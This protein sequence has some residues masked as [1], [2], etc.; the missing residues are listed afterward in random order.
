M[1]RYLH[2]LR[3][4][5]VE[6]TGVKNVDPTSSLFISEFS[7]WIEKR[8]R[9]GS[10]YLELL[11]H[12]RDEIEPVNSAKTLEIGKGKYDSIVKRLRTTIVTPYTEGLEHLNEDRV[13]KG[14]IALFGDRPV[15]IKHLS[16]RDSEAILLPRDTVLMTQNPY[17]PACIMNWTNIHNSGNN[18]IIVGIYGSINDKDRGA[19][20]KQLEAFIERLDE[21]FV[22]QQILV[23][24]TYC[25][26]VA[27]KR[28][29]KRLIKSK[30]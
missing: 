7:D 9:I 27:S 6:A 12:M 15:L 30:H 8:Q 14:D 21:P 24:D 1:K 29:G 11:R 20:A 13:I 25:W 2:S 17:S 10:N 22:Q 5:F 4:Q 28:R 18:D 23:Y 19:K 16:V 26:A 3:D